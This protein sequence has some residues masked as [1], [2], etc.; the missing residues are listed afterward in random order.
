MSN[1]GPYPSRLHVRGVDKKPSMQ[2]LAA[3]FRALGHVEY[4]VV[5]CP[6]PDWRRGLFF[7]FF[8]L[9]FLSLSLGYINNIV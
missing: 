7:F 2:Q 6:H 3:R 5:R 9:F 4:S 8:F 1:H